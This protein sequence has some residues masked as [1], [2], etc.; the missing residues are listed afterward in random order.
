MKRTILFYLVLISSISANAWVYQDEIDGINYE[1]NTDVL[2]A[3]VIRK[4]GNYKGIIEIPQKVL[5]KGEF[6]SVTAIGSSAFY[7][8]SNLSSVTIPQSVTTI[9]AYAF[10]DCNL[11]DIEIP[12]S[13]MTIEH[14]AFAKCYKLM[15][16]SIPNSVFN[17]GARAFYHC[18]NLNSVTLVSLNIC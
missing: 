2:N 18:V 5:Y 8:C 16:V 14:H 6:Y 10:Y 17:I 15:S 11:S 7:S 1:F 9:G 4:D 13:V 12:S 3:V